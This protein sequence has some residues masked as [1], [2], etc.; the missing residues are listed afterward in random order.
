MK[1]E[2]EEPRIKNVPVGAPFARRIWALLAKCGDDLLKVKLMYSFAYWNQILRV[3]LYQNRAKNDGKLLSE[4]LCK[5]KV[6]LLSGRR[7]QL[8]T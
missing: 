7:C 5:P 1:K 6:I 4:L 2:V 8:D 3:P